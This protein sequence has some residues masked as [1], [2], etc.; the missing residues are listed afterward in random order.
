MRPCGSV[1]RPGLAAGS[2]WRGSCGGTRWRMAMTWF[3]GLVYGQVEDRQALPRH[4]RHWS[5]AVGGRDEEGV[6]QV[7]RGSR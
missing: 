3:F 2:P 7:D 4:A 5:E 1:A 6:G